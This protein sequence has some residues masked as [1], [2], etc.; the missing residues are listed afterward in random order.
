MSLSTQKQVNTDSSRLLECFVMDIGGVAAGM[1]CI[2][3][4]GAKME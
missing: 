2:F 1:G 3:R 4:N